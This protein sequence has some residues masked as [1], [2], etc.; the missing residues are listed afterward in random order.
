MSSDLVPDRRHAA[1]WPRWRAWLAAALTVAMLA[2]S[3]PIASSSTTMAVGTPIVTA[4]LD[5]TMADF[6]V[7]PPPAGLSIADEAGGELRRAADLE[8]YF[9]GPVSPA[10]WTWGTWNGGAYNPAPSGGVLFVGATGGSAWLRSNQPFTQRALAGRVTFGPSPWQ[11]IGWGGDG[12]ADRWAILSTAESTGTVYARTF[13]GLR[14][15]RTSLPAVTIGSPHDFRIAWGATQVD[16]YVDGA[17]AAS[18]PVSIAAP[19]YVYSSVN[20]GGRLD[21]GWLRV[22]S[23]AAGATAY[24]SCVKDAGA[25]GPWARLAWDGQTPAGTGLSLET[26]SSVDNLSWSGWSAVAVSGDPIASPA[27]RYLQYRATLTSSTTASPRLDD[28]AYTTAADTPTPTATATSTATPVGLA[29]PVTTAWLDTTAADFAA[30]A[31]SAGLAIA[32]EAGGEVRRAAAL[33]DYFDAPVSTG[34][35]SWGTWNATTYSPAPAGGLL[36]VQSAA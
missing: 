1:R 30:G 16:Y 12:F 3:T 10:L 4:R 34:L 14:E 24:V 26:R 27:G 35:W 23:Y 32:D 7:C 29:L 17:L 2:T 36:P 5:T 33:E 22:E 6:A 31:L 18:H 8:D 20:G 21:L 11:H 13:D 9:T 19:M 15:L 28:I 25:V